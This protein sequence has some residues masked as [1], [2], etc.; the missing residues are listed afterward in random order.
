MSQYVTDTHA[1]CWHLTED[2]K[3]S[4]MAKKIFQ[5]ADSG[6]HQ[7]LIPS[8]VLIEMVYLAEKDRISDSSLNQVLELIDIIGGSYDETPINKETVKALKNIPRADVPDMPDRIITATAYQLDLPLITKDEKIR[9]SR[10]I[11]VVW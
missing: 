5:D 2:P 11:S 1:L 4:A 6:V 3:L 9:N 8:I 7:I 10:V